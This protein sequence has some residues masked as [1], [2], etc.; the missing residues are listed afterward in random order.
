[1][2]PMTLEAILDMARGAGIQ[3]STTEPA[4]VAE[5]LIDGLR[6]DRYFIL[7][8]SEEGDRRFRARME[9]VLARRDPEPPRVF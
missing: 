5:H 8:T 4:E 3:L 2:P 7:P 6:H 1:M 9:A